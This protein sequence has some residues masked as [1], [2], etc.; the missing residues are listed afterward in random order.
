MQL[1]VIIP[2]LNEKDN[3]DALL[4]G[5]I[6]VLNGA[7]Y[8][9]EILVADGGST[10]GTQAKVAAWTACAPVR[11]VNAHSGRGLAGDVLLAAKGSHGRVVVIMDGDLSHPPQIIPALVQP[12]LEGTRDMVIGSRYVAGGSTKGWPWI[13]RLISRCAGLL[14]RPLVDVH[15]P[16][17][18]FFAI[19]RD[20]LAGVDPNA[21]GFKIGLEILLGDIPDLRVKEL[22]ICFHNRSLGR[23]KMTL[24][25]AGTYVRRLL[26]LTG[27]T[28]TFG[29]SL[30]FAVV[31]LLGMGV[32]FGIFQALWKAGLGLAFSH[33]LSFLAATGVNFLLNSR[34]AFR[35]T[36]GESSGGVR[37]VKFL[38][39]C[40]MALFL[41]G[42]VLALVMGQLG[43][44][45]EVAFV[46]AVLVAAGVN[47]IGFAFFVFTRRN[48]RGSEMN[49]RLVAVGLIAYTLVLRLV[50]LGL[51]NLLPEEAYYWNYAQHPAL[52]YLDHPPMVAWLIWLGTSV[53]GNSEFG[54]RAG[55]F[56]CWFVSAG[57]LIGL[58]RNLFDRRTALLTCMLGATLP[59]FF[60]LGMLALPDAPLIACW[61]GA[62]FFLERCLL[63]GCRRAWWGVGVC[64]GLGLLSKY[65]IALLGPATLTFILMDRSARRW[66]LRPHPLAAIGLAL[67]IFS[68]VILWNAENGWASFAF[69]S[70]RRVNANPY[71]ST[72]L[73]IGSI[74]VLVTPLGALAVFRIIFRRP[75]ARADLSLTESD[76]R[77][78]RLFIWVFTVV[79]MLVFVVFSIRH[80][81]K[82]NWTGPV[83]L[84]ALPAIANQIFQT[85]NAVY[86]HLSWG[87]V[88]AALMIIY[89]GML[90]YV[91]IG[92]PG[93]P[94]LKDMA[95]PVAWAQMGKAVEEIENAVES[96]TG[97]EPLV[98]GMDK[99]FIASSLAFYRHS[100]VRNLLEGV[101][102][103]TSR[104][105]VG[106]DALMY[107]YWH[108]PSE[109]SNRQDGHHGRLQAQ[110][111]VRRQ[112]RTIFLVS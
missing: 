42:G 85:R 105:L 4:E 97:Q 53:F 73:L 112:N 29:S 18:G 99:Y 62:L 20:K 44:P 38:V 3:I 24:S 72:H 51:P 8:S 9:A 55:S 54:V 45:L 15:D 36:F 7:P 86:K 65:T 27:G 90:H 83:F 70:I 103:T 30:R 5:V 67:M 41:R 68:P 82:L 12:I 28:I 74:L 31:G 101:E 64:L 81:V 21:E 106:K 11:L 40:M 23:S 110:R 34:W 75:A 61:A 2:T 35:T 32:D 10:D 46:S 69:Q 93:V 14:V 50:Y 63:A 33:I 56:L 87:P 37:Y 96:G 92:I 89:G 71:F 102:H 25:Q 108:L 6:Q 111:S 16:T 13:R 17:S 80:Q 26:A 78:R 58:G 60:S 109:P 98:V 104:N 94:Y 39:V 88:M 100:P 48:A 66:L 47:Y 57:F 52:G 19:R 22:P 49:W 95:L 76:N 79:P 1:S 43:W 77:R 59:I 107:D 91:T 84:V